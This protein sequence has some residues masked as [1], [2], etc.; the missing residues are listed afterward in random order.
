V[1]KL[2]VA[3]AMFRRDGLYPGFW[4]SMEHATPESMPAELRDDRGVPRRAHAERQVSGWWVDEGRARLDDVAIHDDSLV[5]NQGGHPQ[6]PKLLQAKP[7][8]SGERRRKR[9]ARRVDLGPP[10]SSLP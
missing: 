3:S 8:R 9:F 5:M 1:R 10:R 6:T 4:E 7:L 2:V